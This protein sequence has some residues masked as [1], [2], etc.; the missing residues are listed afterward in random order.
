MPQPPPGQARSPP[1]HLLPLGRPC[2]FPGCGGKERE[3]AGGTKGAGLPAAR[4]APAWGGTSPP[5]CPASPRCSP[6]LPASQPALC[7]EHRSRSRAAAL[8]SGFLADTSHLCPPG[9][10]AALCGWTPGNIRAS[11]GL[12]PSRHPEPG[13]GTGGDL[14]AL[15]PVPCSPLGALRPGDCG[16]S[17]GYVCP[18]P[19]SPAGCPAPRREL[20]LQFWCEWSWESQPCS[21]RS[22]A[23]SGVWG[24]S[25]A[26]PGALLEL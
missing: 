18:L 20:S 13:G 23:G 11:A 19:H 9:H 1:L 24:A 8:P 25:P 17:L 2:E 3:G 12:G 21:H 14:G 16:W 10:P 5:A 15:S 7:R 26:L 4:R 6:L 22:S